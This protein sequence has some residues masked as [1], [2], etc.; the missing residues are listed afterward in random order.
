MF[1]DNCR[2]WRFDRVN[3]IGPGSDGLRNEDQNGRRMG[4][5]YVEK[6]KISVEKP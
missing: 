1:I 4:D 6:N 2:L 5:D 3:H